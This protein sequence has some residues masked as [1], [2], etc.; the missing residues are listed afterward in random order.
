M[1]DAIGEIKSL[2]AAIDLLGPSSVHAKPLL[3]ALKAAQQRSK[4]GPIQE[5]LDSC[6][7]F[8]E[9]AKKRVL[10]ADE[11]I[12]RA[13]EQKAIFEAEVAQAEQRLVMLEAEAVATTPAVVPE[14]A[15]V[16]ELQ[17]QIDLLVRERDAL[18]SATG[19]QVGG[20]ELSA[21]WMGNGP[22]CVE[23]L[24]PMP[25][26]NLQ[27]Q[28]RSPKRHGVRRFIIDL[29]DWRSGGSRRWSGRN[30]ESRCADGRPFEIFFDVNVNRDGRCQKTLRRHW[31]RLC[32]WPESV[33]IQ[34]R[35]GFRGVR[36]GE[37]SHPGPP[38]RRNRSEDSTDAVW[39][40]LE[41]AL[42][43]ID[44][45]DDESQFIV[46]TWRDVDS[47]TEGHGGR[48]VRARIGDVAFHCTCFHRCFG[49]CPQACGFS[50]E[51]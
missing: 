4:V 35:Y 50:A 36:V 28:L 18:K 9:R 39:T 51:Q 13:V 21:P 20:G 1:N 34:A 23:K 6:R 5:R 3:I 45:S 42:T 10:R 32:Q 27:P 22:P 41:A 29:E 2:K 48:S 8:I 46:P 40:S 43:R 11:V 14:P 26:V 17:T 33:T 25:T 24:P 47:G 49:G 38:K 31:D 19:R 30:F 37:A 12:A 15:Q 16:K 7:Q 44:D